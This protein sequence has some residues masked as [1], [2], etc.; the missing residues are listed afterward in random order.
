MNALP[1]DQQ[2]GKG[3]ISIILWGL[4]QDVLDEEGSPPLLGSDGQGPHGNNNDIRNN[5][6]RRNHRRGSRG[7]EK[8]RR[9]SSPN[10]DRRE[11]NN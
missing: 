3:R 7:G 2:D 1:P 8:T 9:L 11:G 5:N 6:K 10:R 4:A